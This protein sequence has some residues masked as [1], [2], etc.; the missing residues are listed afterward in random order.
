[1]LKLYTNIKKFLTKLKR[2][3]IPQEKFVI[4]CRPR[5]VEKKKKRRLVRFLFLE[6]LQI[7][8]TYEDVDEYKERKRKENE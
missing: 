1:M 2:K 8:M 5:P 6:L 4:G 7:F 3:I